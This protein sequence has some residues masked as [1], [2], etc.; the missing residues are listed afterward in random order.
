MIGLQTGRV[1]VVDN[2]PEEAFPLLK[3]FSKI[4]IASTYYSGDVTELPDTPL[5]GVRLVALDLHLAGDDAQEA[6]A[7]LSA[8]LAVISRLIAS[9]NGP[10]V[11][12]AWTKHTELVDSLRSKLPS[13]CSSAHPSFVIPIDKK[14]LKNESGDFDVARI[15]EKLKEA[16]REWSPLDVLLLWEQLVHDSASETTETLSGL[17]SSVDV[18][19][20][21]ATLKSALSK[22]GKASSGRQT[23]GPETFL[24][25]IL[26]TLNL[27]HFDRMEHS[28]GDV[29]D[30]LTE[31]IG[32]LNGF[33]GS[34]EAKVEKINRMLILAQVKEGDRIVRPGNL[35]VRDGWHLGAANFPTNQ[36]QLVKELFE[37]SSADFERLKTT[38]H[39][40]LVEL[41]PTCDFAQNKNR[42]GRLI[43]GLLVPANPQPKFIDKGRGS[44]FYKIGPFSINAVDRLG[45]A[46]GDYFLALSARFVYSDELDDLL[47]CQPGARL[48]QQVLVDLQAWFASHAA[49][50]GMLTL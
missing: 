40:A 37:S 5:K 21:K 39:P 45:V 13:A 43:A 49:R 2:D 31:S 30:D 10:F 36:E 50:P 32:E 34:P 38:C 48:R 12:L 44:F 9:E 42:M 1:V 33:S 15:V 27:V 46:P 41:T 26:E 18:P 8:P 6:R 20:W 47:T 17:A 29:P 19:I 14:E 22:L 23:V 16:A 11:V 7:I 28:A 25:A 35:Y 4:G 24:R 3:A